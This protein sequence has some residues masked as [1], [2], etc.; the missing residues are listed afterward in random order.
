VTRPLRERAIMLMKDGRSIDEL[1]VVFVAEGASQAEVD[2]VLAELASLQRKAVALD[3]ARLRAE[4]QWM[5]TQNATVEHV[6]ARFVQLGVAEEHARPEAERIFAALSSMRPCQR[7]GTPTP[8]STFVFDTN[9]FSICN[10]CNLRDEITRS[11]QRGFARDLETFA[12]LGGVGLAVVSAAAANPPLPATTN[13]FCAHCR[14]PTGVHI[15]SLPPDWRARLDPRWPWV[16]SHCWR[17]I[18]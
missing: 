14:T 6:V 5:F 7:C 1:R 16:C 12:M 18:A 8:P 15:A 11:E 9:G 13:P 3:P 2:A 10:G 17:P 4:A